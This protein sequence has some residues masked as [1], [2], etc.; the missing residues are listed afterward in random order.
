MCYN[1]P[2]ETKNKCGLGLTPHLKCSHFFTL[3]LSLVL[4]D[5]IVSSIYILQEI[6]DIYLRYV[7]TD[8]ILCSPIWFGKG[9]INFLIGNDSEGN[10]VTHCLSRIAMEKSIQ[11]YLNVHK[12]TI[13]INVTQQQ[14]SK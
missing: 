1:N 6:N 10:C 12:N 4:F 5:P 7:L 13:K 3:P 2:F 8:L 14:P 11:T 9:S